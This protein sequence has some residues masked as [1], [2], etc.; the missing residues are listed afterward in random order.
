MHRYALSTNYIQQKDNDQSKWVVVYIDGR[1]KEIG[2][3]VGFINS[4]CLG[5]TNRKTTCIIE[6]HEGNRVFVFV[7]KSISAREELLIDYNLNHID[8]NK[9]TIMGVVHT[10]YHLNQLPINDS[11]IPFYY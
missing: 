9:V 5:S 3:I 11:N 4:T 10:I 6:V 7:I 2:N 8:T 1:P